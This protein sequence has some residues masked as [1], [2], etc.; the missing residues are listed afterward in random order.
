MEPTFISGTHKDIADILKHPNLICHTFEGMETLELTELKTM[1]ILIDLQ[2]G[3]LYMWFTVNEDSI[4]V[5]DTSQIK[6]TYVKKLIEERR[7][8][9][10][11]EAIGKIL[12]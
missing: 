6:F 7:M 2:A 10:R 12:S 11:N 5:I 9:L 4:H 3:N 1:N 8:V